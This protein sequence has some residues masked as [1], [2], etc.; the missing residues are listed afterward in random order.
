MRLSVRFLGTPEIVLDGRPVALPRMRCLAILALVAIRRAPMTRAS[1]ASTLW[2]DELS[3]AARANVRRHVHSILSALPPV[4]GIEWLLSDAQTVGW[5]PAAPV[6][7]DLQ[8]FEDAAADRGRVAEAVDLYRGELLENCYEECILA[9]RER[10]HG[11]F[12][13]ACFSAAI[14]ARQERQFAQAIALADRILGADPWREDAL[15]LGMSLRYES[16]DRSSALN[17]FEEFAERLADEVRVTPTPE[18]LAVRD[19]VLANAPV[20]IAG[21]DEVEN[22]GVARAAGIPLPFVGRD[23]ERRAFEAAWHHAARRRGGTIFIGGEAGIGKS[24][25]VAEFATHVSAQGGRILV[26]ETTDP[27]AYPYEALVD[28]LRNGLRAILESPPDGPWLTALSEVLPEVLS[29]TPNL[30]VPEPLDDDTSRTRLFEAFVRT[31]ERLAKAR[32]V[33]IVLEDL[34]WARRATFDA[35]EAIARRLASVPALIAIT[36]RRNEVRADHPL[37]ELRRRLQAQKLATVIDV[38]PLELVDVERIVRATQAGET[39]SDLATSLFARSEGNPLFVGLLLRELSETGRIVREAGG[40]ADIEATVAARV[41]SLDSQTQIL[42]RA[43]STAGRSFTTDL[44]AAVLGWSDTEVLDG[45]R[46]LL[47]RGFVRATES[48]AFS[49]TFTHGLIESSIYGLVPDAE[50]IAR[51]RRIA[52]VLNRID[53]NDRNALSS[54]ARHWKLGGERERAASAF[55]DAARGARSV[56][57]YDDAVTLARE[58]LELEVDELRRFEMLVLVA[59]LGKHRGDPAQW[60]A[61]IADL[62]DAAEALGSDRERFVAA[63]TEV[64]FCATSFQ[65]ERQRVA[66]ASML[67]MAGRLSARERAQALHELGSLDFQEGRIASCAEALGDA[68]ALGGRDGDDTTLTYLWLVQA[69]LRLGRRDEAISHARTMS[70]L[71]ETGGATLAM[72]LRLLTT[73]RHLAE[74][75]GDAAGVLRAGEAMLPLA[76]AAGDMYVETWAHDAIAYGALRL[77]SRREVNEH[78]DRGIELFEY[79][80]SRPRLLRWVHVRAHCDLYFGLAQA[81]LD[82][83]DALAVE[84]ARSATAAQQLAHVNLTRVEC[85]LY[86]GKHDEAL[87]AARAAFERFESA[88]YTSLAAEAHEK[89]GTV[90]SAMGDHAGAIAQIERALEFQRNQGSPSRAMETLSAY[91]GALLGAGRNDDA[92]AIAV[93]LAAQYEKTP[94]LSSRPTLV[95]W[96]LARAAAVAQRPA[97]AKAYAERGKAMIE[98]EAKRFAD[99]EAARAF[100]ALPFNRGLLAM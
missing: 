60:E 45:M 34:H 92:Q 1:L 91:L 9:E 48:S 99:D 32:P 38:R 65:R 46:A 16:G 25:L 85:L 53:P 43:A 49:Y 42:A 50:R 93:E 39:G 3:E 5:N 30:P 87:A 69:L 8:Q 19:A 12:V 70:E 13:D 83:L 22:D 35:L 73:Q 88:G 47:D 4:D 89:A 72:R 33:L 23:E 63:Q 31:I 2:P 18:T 64:N 24:R 56:Y 17:L 95:L 29:A 76:I 77:R 96:L 90:L 58:A 20:A 11:V 14:A 97:L 86:V 26:G 59:D 79:L 52:S 27:E 54:I 75:D 82:R 84:Y 67:D 74:D 15:R 61:D 51:H 28:A 100:R 41:A 81:A 40:A 10:L 44:L 57:A 68:I 37:A 66:I 62:R 71:C 36:Y 21:F 98:R 6:W 80:N 7:I 55:A 78:V 94:A